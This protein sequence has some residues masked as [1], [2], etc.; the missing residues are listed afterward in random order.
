[1]DHETALEAANQAL[2]GSALRP[3]SRIA[4]VELKGGDALRRG[5]RA[6]PSLDHQSPSRSSEA[7][8]IAMMLAVG[9]ATLV[10]VL[11]LW[12]I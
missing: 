9:V 8:Q 4:S 1:V 6:L 10:L 5:G 2:S 11:S 3:E 7:W 12:L